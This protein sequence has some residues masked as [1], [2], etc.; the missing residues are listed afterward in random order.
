MQKH[1]TLSPSDLRTKLFK[2]LREV[3]KKVN[4]QSVK[5]W[6][7]GPEEKQLQAGSLQTHPSL[8][9]ASVDLSLVLIHEDSCPIYTCNCNF[10]QQKILQYATIQ[11]PDHWTKPTAPDQYDD[12]KTKPDSLNSQYVKGKTTHPIFLLT[13]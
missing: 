5:K 4:K 7:A 6:S 12:K 2:R 10:H 9:G 13:L 1:Q 11:H 3:F 8:L